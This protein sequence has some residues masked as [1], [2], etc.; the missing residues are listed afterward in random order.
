MLDSKKYEVW[1]R[2]AVRYDL[3]DE[4]PGL[5]GAGLSK[6]IYLISNAD[7]LLETHIVSVQ[8]SESQSAGAS[9]LKAVST[10][11]VGKRWFVRAFRMARASGDNQWDSIAIKDSVSNTD[12]TWDKTANQTEQIFITFNPFYMEQ[13]DFIGVGLDGTGSSA[14]VIQGEVLCDEMDAF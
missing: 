5:R 7:Q 13:G 6:Q 1:R 4:P 10:V 2:L 3:E 9:G 14:T 11:P 8:S 12:I